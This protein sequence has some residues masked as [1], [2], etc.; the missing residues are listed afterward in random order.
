MTALS[1]VITSVLQGRH[2]LQPFLLALR[3]GLFLPA[4]FQPSGSAGRRRSQFNILV[5]ALLS[6][7]S[8]LASPSPPDKIFDFYLSSSTTS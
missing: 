4:A 8:P 2:S 6:F 3:A 7:L 1:A 5:L